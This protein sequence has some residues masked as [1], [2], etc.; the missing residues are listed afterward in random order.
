MWKVNTARDIIY[1]CNFAINITAVEKILK[2]E[3]LVP[4]PVSM[5][6]ILLNY[7]DAH[8]KK[9]VLSNKLGPLGFNL[10]WMFVVDLMHK[11]KL[12]IWRALFI[13]LLRILNAVGRTLV[14]EL[15]HQYVTHLLWVIVQVICMYQA[16]RF[17][18]LPTFGHDAIWQ[19]SS[20]I[21]EL[22]RLITWYFEDILQ[23][24]L[25]GQAYILY[26]T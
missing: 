21:S 20:N 15:D 1:N 13:H 18:Q 8:F 10:F 23:V 14:D 17:W 19:F 16:H 6:S 7:T 22:K 26:Q 12:G 3:L 9:N 2:P 4:T 25:E 11:V 24:S 5:V